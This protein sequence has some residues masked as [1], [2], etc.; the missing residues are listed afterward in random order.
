MIQSD[1]LGKGGSLSRW[2][3]SQTQPLSLCSPSKRSSLLLSSRTKATQNLLNNS[4]L[5][6][7][8]RSNRRH[9]WQHPGNGHGRPSISTVRFGCAPLPSV[10]FGHPQQNQA[11]RFPDQKAQKT[12]PVFVVSIHRFG[13]PLS[14]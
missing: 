11:A 6:R 14:V 1:K 10:R 8:F 13:G 12:R 9:G 7:P 5:P 4:L 2:E 3:K